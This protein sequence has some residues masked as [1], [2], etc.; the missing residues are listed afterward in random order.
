MYPCI[1][2]PQHIVCN[3]D[4]TM[5]IYFSH[6]KKFDY[7]KELYEPLRNSELAKHHRFIFPHEESE[8]PYPTKE[9]FQSK[10]CNLVIAEVSF[11]ATGQGIELGWADVNQIPIACIYLT[12]SKIS[13]SLHVVSDLFFPYKKESLID[14]ITNIVAIYE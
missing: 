12:D 9:L 2:T 8:K 3:N 13:E 11:P 4:N 7:K 6:S 1:D 14:I 10:K 5:N